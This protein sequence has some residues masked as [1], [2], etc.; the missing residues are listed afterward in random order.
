MTL[1]IH[2]TTVSA[3]IAGLSISGVTIKDID[4]IPETA[5][6][7]CPLLVPQPNN[8][9]ANI[10]I[11]NKSYGSNGTQKADF[12]YD[13]N[14]AFLYCEAGA[15]INTYAPYAGLLAKLEDVLETVINNDVIS[16][17]V[18]MTLTG[19]SNVGIIPDPADNEYWGVLVTLHC[20]EY[21]Q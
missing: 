19:I 10:K 6:M 3:S 21:A 1:S 8:F 17:L 13:L 14:Y 16:G 7:L 4:E 20:L 18:D 12:E 15:G 9:I 2:P 5:N 11:N